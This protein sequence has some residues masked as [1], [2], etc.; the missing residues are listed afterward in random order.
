MRSTDPQREILLP[1]LLKSLILDDDLVEYEGVL[2]CSDCL[3]YKEII[4]PVVKTRD[5]SLG[6]AA[7]GF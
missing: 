2:Y 5:N 7:I 3:Y 1:A 4:T 6:L